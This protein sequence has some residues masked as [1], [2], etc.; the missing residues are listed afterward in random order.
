MFK[1]KPKEFWL[2]VY[3]AALF[4]SLKISYTLKIWDELLQSPWEVKV[5]SITHF[6]LGGPAVFFLT[7]YMLIRKRKSHERLCRSQ[8]T[9]T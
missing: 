4:Y 9:S 6:V 7:R 5:C 8:V 1:V 3:A 2:A